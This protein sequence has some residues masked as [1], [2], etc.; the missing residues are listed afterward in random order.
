MSTEPVP[1]GF[2]ES[3][4]RV[5]A[6]RDHLGHWYCFKC[7]TF[8]SRD[9]ALVWS[10]VRASRCYAC[11]APFPRDGATISTLK[12]DT[13]DEMHR[14]STPSRVYVFYVLAAIALGGYESGFDRPSPQLA[15]AQPSSIAV[16]RSASADS[17]AL[18]APILTPAPRADAPP[19][20]TSYEQAIIYARSGDCEAADMS[21]SS[22]LREAQFCTRG[23][24]SEGYLIVDLK[25]RLYIHAGVP[26]DVW[27][28][29]KTAESAG[30]FYT[31]KIRGRYRL[32]L[33][34]N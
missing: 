27:S 34:G 20:F 29:F 22:V 5:L 11:H 4:P 25:G 8:S 24:R 7:A 30:R 1:R 33:G 21:G 16:P 31:Y 28:A 9:Y 18:S 6:V 13:D 19:A 26:S 17:A 15:P 3:P 12:S 32:S 2:I 23:D 14:P 10:A